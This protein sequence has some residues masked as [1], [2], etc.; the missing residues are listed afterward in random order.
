METTKYINELCIK[1]ACRLRSMGFMD[2][3]KENVYTNGIYKAVFRDFLEKTEKGDEHL[4]KAIE[5]LLDKI[6]D[7]DNFATI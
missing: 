4:N 3:S 2:A 7:P 5:I 1:G 6:N